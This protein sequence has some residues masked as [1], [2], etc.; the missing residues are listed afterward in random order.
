MLMEIKIMFYSSLVWSMKWKRG[1]EQVP[2]AFGPFLL[3][4]PLPE[5]GE[6]TPQ[7]YVVS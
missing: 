5:S 7:G 2:Q 1:T 4:S 3:L 6:A